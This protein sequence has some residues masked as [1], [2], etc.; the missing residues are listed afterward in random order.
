MRWPW[1]QPKLRR[2]ELRFL[3]YVDADRLIRETR[4]AWTIA[5]EE[6]S[7]RNVGMVYIER[8]EKP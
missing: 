6:D 8:L 7:N 4:G 5:P 2:L 1:R 3:P